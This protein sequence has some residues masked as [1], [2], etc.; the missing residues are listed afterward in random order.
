MRTVGVIQARASSTRLPGKVLR[1]LGGRPMLAWQLDRLAHA[2]TI[3]TW[4]VATSGEPADDAV[5][6]VAEKA[7]VP[8]FRGS[9]HDVLDRYYACARAHAASVVLRVT[10]DCP[11]HHPDV[12]DFVMDVFLR[13]SADY[14]TNA[15]PPSGEDGFDAE[16]FTFAA[17]ER[18]WRVAASPYDREH[19]TSALRHDASLRRVLRKY[20]DAYDYKLS[21]DTEQDFRLVEKIVAA[22]AGRDP[23]FTIDEVMRCLA[24][25][26]EWDA[27]RMRVTP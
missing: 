5:V 19:V 1:E 25:H 8:S 13:E 21:V 3:D 18:A 24:E 15:V 2:R 6:A 26:P 22:L 10:A 14:C 9:L 16:A 11:L 17:L 23:L 20:R 4:V 12:V 7:G 27:P